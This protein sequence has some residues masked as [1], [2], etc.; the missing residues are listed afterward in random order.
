MCGNLCLYLYLWPVCV[1]EF[2]KA[3]LVRRTSAR[4]V[5]GSGVDLVSG[6]NP[7]IF[8]VE[9]VR[10]QVLRPGLEQ[11]RAAR[12]FRGPAHRLRHESVDSLLANIPGL[13]SSGYSHYV[14]RCAAGQR[15]PISEAVQHLVDAAPCANGSLSRKRDEYL[16]RPCSDCCDMRGSLRA[17]SVGSS[18]FCLCNCVNQ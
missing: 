4:R 12:R 14:V 5:P 11:T 10:E 6:C 15:L 17:A 9:I 8:H 7:A 1:C 3:S 13:L 18:R 2:L 16:D